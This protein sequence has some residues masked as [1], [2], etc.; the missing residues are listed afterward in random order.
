M[1]EKFKN[2]VFESLSQ[3]YLDMIPES[4]PHEFS[5]SFLKK[6]SSL[7]KL[8]KMPCYFLLKSQFGRAA[9]I[10]CL[11][12]AVLLTTFSLSAIKGTVF[13]FFLSQCEECS[14]L[15]IEDDTSSPQTI[16]DFYYL[17]MLD[18]SDCIIDYNCFKFMHIVF[19][20]LNG[21]T[22]ALAQHVRSG[23]KSNISTDGSII[24]TVDLNGKRAVFFNVKNASSSPSMLLWDNGDYV[25]SVSGCFDLNEL[26][27]LA[28]SVEIAE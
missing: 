9:V 10:I 14:I 12:C 18:K 26:T 13:G 23:Y 21:R 20:N 16:E 25:L 11:I 4:E 3:E 15:E 19:Y 6:M 22:V 7:V 27:E 5:D 28:L 17:G 24:K 2:A 8:R 1:S